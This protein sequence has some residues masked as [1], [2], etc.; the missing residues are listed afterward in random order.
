MGDVSDAVNVGMW[1]R[2]CGAKEMVSLQTKFSGGLK[3]RVGD[4]DD[5]EEQR[6]LSFKVNADHRSF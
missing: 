2:H 5:V 6:S 4:G 1:S 3:E